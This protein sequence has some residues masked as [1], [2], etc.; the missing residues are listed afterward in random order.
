MSEEKINDIILEDEAIKEQPINTKSEYNLLYKLGGLAA[1]I[2]ALLFLFQLIFMKWSTYPSNIGEWYELFGRSRTLGIFYLNLFD[3]ITMILLGVMFVALCVRLSRENKSISELSKPFAFLGIAM[4][5]IPRTLMMSVI[6]L[7]A[8]YWNAANAASQNL[9]YAAGKAISIVIVPTM[10][11]T[12]F[13]IIAIAAFLLSTV[14][15]I[16]NRMPKIGGFIGIMAFLL[17]IAVN[18]TVSAAQQLA[19]PMMIVTSIFWVLWW[20]IVSAGLFMAKND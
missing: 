14:I 10:Q 17:T 11:T 12:G 6:T 1:A 9:L 8:E 15:I 20:G 16:S 2:A 4:F 7:S 13:F 5:V 18:I 3:I 19:A